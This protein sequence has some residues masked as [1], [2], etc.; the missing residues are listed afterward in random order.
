MLT[1]SAAMA[2]VPPLEVEPTEIIVRVSPLSGKILSLDSASRLV[3]LSSSTFKSSSLAVGESFELPP[4]DDNPYAEPPPFTELTPELLAGFVA[5]EINGDAGY[6]KW[7]DHESNPEIAELLRQ[8][9]SEDDDQRLV[10]EFV[11]RVGGGG[12][13]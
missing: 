5:G 9:L 4:L 3:V 13:A 10:Q 1:P 6:Q 2:A 12:D 8:N 7:A 11:E